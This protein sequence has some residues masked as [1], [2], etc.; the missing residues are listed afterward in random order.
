MT[1]PSITL[2]EAD[3][4]DLDRV[5]AT[6]KANDLPYRDVRTGP[7]RFFLA[8]SDGERVGVGGVEI[9]G[10]NGLLRSVAVAESSRGRGYGT[11]LC[12]ALEGYARENGVTTLYLL[13]TTASGFFQ[14]R[15]Y[16]EVDREDVPSSVRATTEFADLCPASATCMG[17]RLDG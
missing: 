13:T 5:E 6:L 4:D 7:G 14:G 11:A 2:R 9:H 12:E 10:T 17:K 1:D 8:R 15:G 16:G 3:A